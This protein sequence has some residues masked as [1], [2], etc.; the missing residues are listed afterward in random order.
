[1]IFQMAIP[2]KAEFHAHT[3]E[4]YQELCPRAQSPMPLARRVKIK[5]YPCIEGHIHR[6]VA[7]H[8]IF[9]DAVDLDEVGPSLRKDYDDCVKELKEKSLEQPEGASMLLDAQFDKDILPFSDN[10]GFMKS[11]ILRLTYHNAEIKGPIIGSETNMNCD[12]LRAGLN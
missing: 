12:P 5:E 9:G 6:E 11:I 7:L 10:R 1:M 4:D 2:S 8:V 3:P